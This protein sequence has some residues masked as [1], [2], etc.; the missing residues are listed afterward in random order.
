MCVFENV[1]SRG[2]FRQEIKCT[3]AGWSS[4]FQSC[5]PCQSRGA[6][7]GD[8]H[9][10]ATPVTCP[11]QLPVLHSGPFQVRLFSLDTWDYPVDIAPQ[12]LNEWSVA[13]LCLFLCNP[14]GLQ[15]ARLPCPSLSLAVYSNSCPTSRWC[16]PTISCS[17]IPSPALNLS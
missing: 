7:S 13:K 5:G 12:P 15:H 16:H 11:A 10:P 4:P 9:E 8:W 3:D 1:M 6:S 2:A 17:V 14:C